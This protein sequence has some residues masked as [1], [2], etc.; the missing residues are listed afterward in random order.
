MT[1]TTI[2][3]LKKELTTLPPAQLLE[4]C[5]RLARFKKDNKELLGYLLFEAHD[6]EAYIRNVKEEMEADFN[7]LPATNSYLTKKVLRKILRSTAKHIKYTGSKQAE[8]ELLLY[9]CSLIKKTR[10]PLTAGTVIYNMY[11]QQL[12]KIQ[13]IIAAQHEDLQYDYQRQLDRLA[14][15]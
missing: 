2:N 11:R 7:G 10:I 4:I 6:L 14:L 1:K 9:F 12:K 13:A 3:E 8:A 5:L 15:H